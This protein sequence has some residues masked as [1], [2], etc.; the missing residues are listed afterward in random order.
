MVRVTH[1]ALWTVQG[2]VVQRI[3]SLWIYSRPSS[4]FS[5]RNSDK[6]NFR[7]QGDLKGKVVDLE[8]SSIAPMGPLGMIVNLIIISN[9][10][11]AI[12]LTNQKPSNGIHPVPLY[13]PLFLSLTI[14]S[15]C[16]FR[17]S[18]N[19]IFPALPST[20]PHLD[21]ATFPSNWPAW[22]QAFEVFLA[23]SCN[24]ELGDRQK[25][26]ILLHCI[27]VEGREMVSQWIPQLRAFNSPA[28]MGVR[29]CHVW[30]R[31]NAQ[32]FQEELTGLFPTREKLPEVMSRKRGHDE[33]EVDGESSSEVV[34]KKAC[35]PESLVSSDSGI[36]EEIAKEVEAV[37]GNKV[38]EEP[39]T[40]RS[41]ERS[42]LEKE[43]SPAAEEDSIEKKETESEGQRTEDSPPTDSSLISGQ[44][45]KKGE[46]SESS[47]AN[48]SATQASTVT[49]EEPQKG[50]SQPPPQPQSGSTD[51]VGQGEPK[52]LEPI[53]PPLLREGKLFPIISRE[54]TKIAVFKSRLTV[55]TSSLIRLN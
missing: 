54:E 49:P 55:S 40:E 51:N 27:G 1:L 13:L 16:E 2:S 45:D 46:D 41:G 39:A 21:V 11:S 38:A 43:S 23:A 22:R 19:M 10:K 26:A 18:I 36:G 48:S 31:M 53:R 8:R 4:E 44:D 33:K 47:V 42:S 12:G 17:Q 35:P 20:L 28:G 52:D 32:S 50:Q 29:F 3:Q 30:N 24:N 34:P 37:P 25:L 7:C 6:Q 14:Q 9:P 15:T 5:S